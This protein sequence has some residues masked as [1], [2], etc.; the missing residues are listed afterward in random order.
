[1][2]GEDRA[3]GKQDEGPKLVTADWRLDDSRD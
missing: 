2:Q 3:C 1:M